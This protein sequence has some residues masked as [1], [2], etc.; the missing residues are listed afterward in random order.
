MFLIIYYNSFLVCFFFIFYIDCSFFLI[1]V[2]EI[3]IIIWG[4]GKGCNSLNVLE[5]VMC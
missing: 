1:F 4:V 5:S 2:V 3:I